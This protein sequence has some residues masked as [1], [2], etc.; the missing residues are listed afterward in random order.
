MSMR[1]SSAGSLRQDCLRFADYKTYVPGLF[2]NSRLIRHMC[3]V[4]LRI[5]GL[6]DTEIGPFYN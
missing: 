3:W 4:V 6:S 5:G 2:Y 1:R